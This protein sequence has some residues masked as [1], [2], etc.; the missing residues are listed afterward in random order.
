MQ[1][2]VNRR[3]APAPGAD[4]HTHPGQVRHLA[5]KPLAKRFARC[6]RAHRRARDRI[7]ARGRLAPRR[8][9]QGKQS[10]SEQHG[11]QQERRAQSLPERPQPGLRRSNGLH[12]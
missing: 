1:F 11:G 6:E 5:G 2:G 9:P 10:E 8:G 4:A 12:R 7:G 3:P